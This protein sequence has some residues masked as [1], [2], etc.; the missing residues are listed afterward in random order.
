MEH[1]VLI[2]QIEKL[3]QNMRENSILHFFKKIVKLTVR[4]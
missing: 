4:Y 2:D 3:R 1:H